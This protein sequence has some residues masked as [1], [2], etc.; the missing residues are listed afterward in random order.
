MIDVWY[1]SR[2]P[3]Y[4]YTDG[5]DT[6]DTQEGLPIVV[7]RHLY[8]ESR[9]I[10]WTGRLLTERQHAHQIA[11]ILEAVRLGAKLTARNLTRA[12]KTSN[13]RIIKMALSSQM[14]RLILWTMH[15]RRR[16]KTRWCLAIYCWGCSCVN[17]QE[18]INKDVVEV[19]LENDILLTLPVC[20]NIVILHF[21]VLR[22]IRNDHHLVNDIFRLIL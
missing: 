2:F 12:L 17:R 19:F 20:C 8:T 15:W 3:S 6:N 22:P 13:F 10:L 14:S 1:I 16:V 18:T 21:N 4:G 9:P 7:R 5:F 11:S